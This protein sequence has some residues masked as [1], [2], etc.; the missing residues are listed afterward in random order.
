MMTPP[1]FGVRH[2]SPASAYHVEKWLD[3]VQPTAVLI[4][5][6][7]DATSLIADISRKETKPPLAIMAYTHEVPVQTVVY[8][9]AS[10]SPE[11]RAIMWATRHDVHVSFIDLPS[12]I[13]LATENETEPQEGESIYE[14]MALLAGELDYESYWERSYEHIQSSTSFQQ[15]I[16]TFSSHLRDVEEMSDTE[17]VENAHREWFMRQQI[18]QKIEEGHDPTKIA[19]ITGAFHVKGL[20]ETQHIE[21]PSVQPVATSLTLMPYSNF[22]LS[23]RSGYGAGNDAP[24]Y[25]EMMWECMKRGK[26]RELPAYYMT[27][28]ASALRRSGT[29]RSSAEVIEGVRLAHS[30]AS[31]REGF[32]PTL[33]DLRDAATVNLGQGEFSVIA[34]ACAKVETGTNIGFLP[35]G[36]SQTPIQDDFYR[37]I[38]QLKLEKYRKDVKQTLQLDLRENR[39]VKGEE[40]A[41]L[42]L[43]RSFFFHK[44]HVLHISFAVP[45]FYEQENATWAEHWNVQWTPE[46]EMHL[47]ESTLLGESI[48]LAVAF[49]LKEQL[50]DSKRVSKAAEIVYRAFQC[51][52]ITMM[53]EAKSVVQRLTVDEGDFVET[54]NAATNI[55][56][57]VQYGDVR[58]VDTTLL[59]PLVEQLFLRSTLLLIDAARCNNDAAR[60]VMEAMNEVNAIALQLFEHVDEEEW[61]TVLREVAYRDDL[62]PLLSGYACTLLIERNQL[63]S[64]TLSE[65]VARRLS[66]G[67]SVDLGA[68]WFE[69]LCLRNKYALLSRPFLWEQINEYVLS[70]SDEQ[71][72]RALVFLRRAFTSFSSTDRAKVAELLGDLWGGDSLMISEQLN[73]SLT[74]QEEAVIDELND[75]DFGDF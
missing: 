49:R 62:N 60:I 14:R 35:D 58:K 50:E 56:R 43:H 73:E 3:D 40:A 36:V 51:G 38:K 64:K 23:A 66:P 31:F 39:R 68:G 70:L 32:L 15:A 57:V 19:V 33:R 21:I 67:V 5:G 22:K 52:M 18:R 4:E 74:E 24:A 71:F 10:Y 2:L 41:F 37:Q 72:H 30:L 20:K 1:I 45:D 44:L 53:K 59:R 11:Y 63:D 34:E 25:F 27:S 8:P 65:E 7:A 48:D 12:S 17:N 55:A 69:G 75:F 29:F 54:A 13:T 6:P 42:D 26:L 9:L 16:H 47:V 46:V 28:V 61:F